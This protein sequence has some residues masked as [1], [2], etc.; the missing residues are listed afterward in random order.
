MRR[1]KPVAA[2]L[3]LAPA[4]AP[5]RRVL[6]ATDGSPGAARAL[7]QALELRR[8]LRE[9]EQV[10]L[11][12]L[13]VQR[14][15]TGDVASFVTAGSIEDYHRERAEQALAEARQR[16]GTAGLAFKEHQRVGDPGR[17][18]AEVA[19]AEGCELIVM[20]ARGLGTHTAALLG[21]VAAGTLEHAGVPVM[22]VKAA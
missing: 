1:R 17:T 5:I 13:N 2:A 4:G 20:G 6:V 16:L 12:L 14:P 3:P 11:H 21:S 7:E 15:V 22:V 9:G 18:I 8:Q 10:E 19:A